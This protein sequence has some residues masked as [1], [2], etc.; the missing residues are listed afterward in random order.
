[1]V[2]S[3]V[4]K[5]VKA[6]HIRRANVAYTFEVLPSILGLPETSE[7]ANVRVDYSRNIIVFQVRD[8]SFPEIPEGQEAYEIVPSINCIAA[9][10][11]RFCGLEKD[12]DGKHQYWTQRTFSKDENGR[13]VWKQDLVEFE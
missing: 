6:K 5:V 10:G 3:A 11:K 1:M 2:Y 7:I 9:D 8:D 12:H 13:T 4:D